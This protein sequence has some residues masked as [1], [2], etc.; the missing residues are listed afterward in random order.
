MSTIFISHSSKDNDTVVKFANAFKQ[1]GHEIWLDIWNISGRVP[2]WH[3]IQDGIEACSHFVFIVSPDAIEDQSGAMKE[4]YHADS[5]KPP[6]VIIP[7]VVRETPYS[8]FPILIS[9]GR[10]QNHNLIQQGYDITLAKVLFALETTP[11]TLHRQLKQS[12][13]PAADITRHIQG[14]LQ[15]NNQIELER[16]IR[17]VIR[18]THEVFSGDT[19][20]QKLAFPI[21]LEASEYKRIW[22]EYFDVCQNAIQNTILLIWY[23]K[24]SQGKLLSEAISQWATPPKED[25]RFPERKYYLWNYIPGALLLYAIGIS[26]LA[27]RHWNN[28]HSILVAPKSYEPTLDKYLPTVE[29]IVTRL[30]KDY[31]R[32]DL[33]H[34][35]LAPVSDSL[36]A[37]LH[38][39]LKDYFTST[40]AYNNTFDLFEMI[41]SLV[42]LQLDITGSQWVPPHIAVANNRSYPFLREFWSSEATSLLTNGGLFNSDS[43]LL[44]KSLEGVY[45][46]QHETKGF[47]LGELPNYLATYR[48]YMP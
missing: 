6:K 17:T 34:D 13:G 15:A 41:L 30:I 10:L 26:S 8:E 25:N 31:A 27:N 12:E 21:Q 38:P 43:K 7:I 2:Y 20:Y 40:E 45:L 44:E 35:R 14:L 48:K 23:S 42:H 16:A 1:A 39:L 5:L 36:S 22:S 19:F 37:F 18:Q 33:A 29:V 24:N 47:M 3:E 32:Q 9:P 11:T 4:L 46:L 28:L